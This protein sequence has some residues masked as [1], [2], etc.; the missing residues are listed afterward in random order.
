MYNHTH[1]PYAPVRDQRNRD[2]IS[3]IWFP[4]NF[5]AQN[6][7]AQKVLNHFFSFYVI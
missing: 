5:S 3:L 7:R 4:N 6:R 2:L 1:H